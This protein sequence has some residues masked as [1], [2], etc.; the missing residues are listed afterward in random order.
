MNNPSYVPSPVSTTAIHLQSKLQQSVTISQAVLPTALI[1]FTVDGWIHPTSVS[2]YDNI[3]LSMCQRRSPRTCLDLGLRNGTLYLGGYG[4][5]FRS[6]SQ[7]KANHWSHVA[8]VSDST[9]SRQTFYLNGQQYATRATPTDY[10][11][12]DSTLTIGTTKTS[13]V[14]HINFDGYIDH[15]SFAS[16]AKSAEEILKA[17]TSTPSTR[18]RGNHRSRRSDEKLIS[19]RG[20][21]TVA[22]DLRVVIFPFLSSSNSSILVF[23]FV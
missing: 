22:A 6:T 15:L 11:P 5:I 3:L 23:T 14:H 7:L 19:F 1:S 8:L 20:N 21:G 9:V 13:S 16:V 17:A 12:V 10:Q 2:A 4:E 18:P